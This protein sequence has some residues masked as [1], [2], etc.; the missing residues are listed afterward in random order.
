MKNPL[1]LFRREEVLLTEDDIPSHSFSPATELEVFAARTRDIVGGLD[2]Q[3]SN[4]DRQINEA[5]A[6]LGD[7]KRIREGQSLALRYMEGD[8]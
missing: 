5:I 2:E 7:L 1:Q 8:I 3:I 6:R 4:L